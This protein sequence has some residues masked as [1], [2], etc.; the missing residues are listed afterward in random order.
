LSAGTLGTTYLLLRNR[1]AFPHLSKQLGARFSGNGDLLTFA[2]QSRRDGGP[3]ILDVG[4]GPA[5]TCAIRVPDVLDGGRV[6]G[7]Y[8]EDAGYPEHLNWVLEAANVPGVFQRV[9][10]TIARRLRERLGGARQSD[11]SAEMGNLIGD[12]EFTSS[13]MPLLGMGRDVPD[14]SLYLREKWLE[15]DWEIGASR[16]YFEGV[17]STMRDIAHALQ[18]KFVVNPSFYLNRVITVHPLGGCPM[19]RDEREG[20][21]DAYGEVFNYPGLHI[22]DGSVMPGS[23]GPNPSLTIAALANRFAD[24]IIEQWKQRTSL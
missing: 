3:R 4:Y 14:K 19:G 12:A 17:R 1:D 8:I 2:V 23:V 7:H 9:A 15:S 20:V 21:V 24:R 10:R 16:E 6:R 13:L 11:V 22:A 5:I 18:A